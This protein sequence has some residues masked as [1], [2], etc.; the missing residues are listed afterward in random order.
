MF[1]QVYFDIVSYCVKWTCVLVIKP[2]N[3]IAASI[4]NKVCLIGPSVYDG[5]VLWGLRANPFYFFTTRH[6]GQWCS[7]EQKQK[8]IPSVS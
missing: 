5:C 7:T 4:Q 3:F 1:K 2:C 6:L 8:Q